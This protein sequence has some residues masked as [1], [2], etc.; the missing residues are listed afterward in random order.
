VAVS[1][2]ITAFRREA[3]RKGLDLTVSTHQGIPEMVK[4]DPSRLRQVLSNVTSNAFQHSVAGGIKVNIRQVR[5]SEN[6]SVI[7]ITVQ[8]VGLGMSETQLDVC[9]L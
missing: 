8:D 6:N 4:G 9:V 2:V 3:L 5:I 1:E 7:G